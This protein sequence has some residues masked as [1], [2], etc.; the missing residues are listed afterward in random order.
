MAAAERTSTSSAQ[1]E[2]EEE[3]RTRSARS[4]GHSSSRSSSNIASGGDGDDGSDGDDDDAFAM[5]VEPADF[6]PGTPP[7]TKT[8]YTFPHTTAQQLGAQV[9]ELQLVGAH[10]LWGHHLWNAAPTLSNYLAEST[11][12]AK[13]STGLP[14]H[15]T[16]LLDCTGKTVLELGAAAGL[17]S[18]VA[19]HLGA[20][21]VV[22]T[23]YPDADLIENLQ[24]NARANEQLNPTSQSRHG[25]PGKIVVEGY[26]W[27]AE[28]SKIKAHLRPQHKGCFDIVLLSDLIFNHQAH[29]AMLD[30]L[31]AC[32]PRAAAE[33]ERANQTPSPPSIQE[34]DSTYGDRPQALVFFTHHRPHLAHRD[35][36]FF[37]LAEQR[38]WTCAEVG[39]WKMAVCLKMRRG[40]LTVSHKAPFSCFVFSFAF[41]LTAD[42]PRR[43]WQ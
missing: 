4:R 28:T 36:E 22:S 26:I 15:G 12:S 37:A 42:V 35:L 19:R 38:G 9:I 31:D 21:V 13:A 29:G 14:P 5:F 16:G 20:D 27:G 30:T 32:L 2:E 3:A 6:R 10:P 1:V 43:P 8:T 41:F 17:P 11:A 40:G 33:A 24:G 7:P 18:I 25:R 39:R 34:S 23:D